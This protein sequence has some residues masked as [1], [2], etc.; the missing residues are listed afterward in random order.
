[1][2]TMQGGHCKR[3]ES[4]TGIHFLSFHIDI[5]GR[6]VNWNFDIPV[7]KKKSMAESK[8]FTPGITKK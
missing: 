4:L 7:S 6:K 2:G 8:I 1:M 5:E 3:N